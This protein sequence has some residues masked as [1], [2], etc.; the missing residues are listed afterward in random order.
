MMKVIERQDL[1]AKLIKNGRSGISKNFLKAD[2][3]LWILQR[4]AAI[5]REDL[6]YCEHCALIMP[7]A[8]YPFWYKPPL[9]A[10]N[11]GTGT[12]KYFTGACELH[13]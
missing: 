11:E 5:M 12:G 2:R 7:K 3:Y 9:R 6:L 1:A 8:I 10:I 13:E 4:H